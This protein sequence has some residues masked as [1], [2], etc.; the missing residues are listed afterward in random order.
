MKK[1][2]KNEDSCRKEYENSTKE[3]F[4]SGDPADKLESFW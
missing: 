1:A 4:V 3:K 2:I